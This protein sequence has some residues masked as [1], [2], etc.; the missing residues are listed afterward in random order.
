MEN[1]GLNFIIPLIIFLAL[2]LAV[3]LYFTKRNKNVSEYLLAG[4][5]LPTWLA[6]LTMTASIFGGGLL[7]GRC[8]FSYN[9]GPFFLVYAIQGFIAHGLLA[10]LIGKM[11]GFSECATVTQYLELRYGSRFLRCTCAL[12]S[13][14]ALIGITA[15]QVS[16]LMSIFTGMGFQNVRLYACLCMIIILA[17][18]V[19]GGLWAVSVTDAIQIIIVIIGVFALFFSVLNHH[20]GISNIIS[21]LSAAAETLPAGYNDGLSSSKMI[22]L[23]WLMAPSVMYSLIGQEGYQRLFATRNLKEARK[24]AVISGVL[25]SAITI[26]PLM[27]GIAA[28]LDFPELAEQGTSASAFASMVVRYLPGFGSGILLC[29]VLAAILSTADSLLTAAASHF[30]SDFWLLYPAKGAD[31][32]DRKLVR[33]SRLFVLVAGIAA[34]IL[35][36]FLKDLL[37][38]I[39]YVY[40]IYTAG[41]FTP[42]VIGCLWKGAT[43]KGAIA[44]LIVGC[45]VAAAGIAGF[46]V[47]TVPGELLSM[48]V[49]VVVTVAVSLATKKT[50]QMPQAS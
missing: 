9:N 44:G 28:R 48:V 18:T 45:A 47:G 19:M 34:L 23:V 5:G 4:R 27:I 14:V 21:Q 30:M 24:T 38:S 36:M 17:L 26:M 25:I 46:Q 32:N 3:G 1:V 8:Q 50:T 7:V 29:A 12:L 40:T 11:K 39:T 22:L 49:A 15:I 31:P 43:K 2:L 13:I 42:I 10:L 35:S 33:V 20:G 41:A 16:A 37:V 6:V